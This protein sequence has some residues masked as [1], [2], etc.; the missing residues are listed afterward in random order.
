VDAGWDAH[1]FT[2]GGSADDAGIGDLD[3]RRIVAVNPAAWG[4]DL[5][6]FFRTHYP[7]TIYV[8]LEAEKPKQLKTALEALPGL[9]SQPPLQP[10]SPR[11]KPRVPYA[12]TYVLLPPNANAAW[13]HAVVD[14]AW[15]A[16]RFTIGGSADDAGIGDLDFRRIIAVNPAAWGDDLFAF[17]V[18]YYSGVSYV[19][20]NADTPQELATQLEKF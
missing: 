13:A 14:A 17:F 10:N 9:P 7:G 3:F 5:R 4:D 18:T 19:P 2:I 8:P 11:G 1:R 15:D 12:R 20:V 6:A 16:H